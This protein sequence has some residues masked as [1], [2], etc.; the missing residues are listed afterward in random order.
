MKN[1]KKNSPHTFMHTYTHKLK[2]QE[3]I[4]GSDPLINVTTSCS[5]SYYALQGFIVKAPYIFYKYKI[6]KVHSV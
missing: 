6:Y 5:L 2:L 4:I 1:L 3:Y